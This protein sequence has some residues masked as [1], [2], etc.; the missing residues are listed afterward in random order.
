[1]K[2]RTIRIILGSLAILASVWIWR[3]H[4]PQAPLSSDST[5]PADGPDSEKIG[6]T[7]KTVEPHDNKT[8][9]EAA[10]PGLTVIQSCL[11]KLRGMSQSSN[12]RIALLELRASLSQLPLTNRVN[13]IQAFLEGKADAGTG[14]PFTVEKN[15]L[16]SEHPT[17]RTFLL[18]YLGQVAPEAAAQTSLK[19]LETM[20]SPDEWALSLR[21]YA[22]FDSSTDGKQLLAAK[23]NQMLNYGPW[24]EKPSNGFLESFDVAVHLG[25]TVLIPL[26]DSIMHAGDET[27]RHAANLALDRMVIKDTAAS[28][29]LL[30][31]KP[32][33]IAGMEGFRANLFARADMREPKMKELIEQYLLTPSF[34]SQ[35]IKVFVESF[36][37]DNFRIGNNLLT[38]DQTPAGD[39]LV[40]K[41]AASLMIIEDWLG[42]ERFRPVRGHLLAMRSRL[43]QFV[44][45]AS[46]KES[47]SGERTALP[48]NQ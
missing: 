45:Q 39:E 5:L 33:L 24:R 11:N 46:N 44:A 3:A 16:L 2:A 7:S 20:E 41:D 10:S 9:A 23:L 22:R 47:Q 18:D 19:I 25:N 28:L 8:E 40:K 27:L 29:T 37:N 43:L 26:L 1:M 21:N 31:E 32:A 35:E 14:L 15:G 6:P 30:L 17:L 38:T 12:S 48:S 36:P 4:R 13:A 42:Q 34:N